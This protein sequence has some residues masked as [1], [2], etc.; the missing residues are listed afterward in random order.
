MWRNLFLLGGLP[1]ILLVNANIILFEEH[2]P[3][4]PDFAPFEYMRKRQKV[5][6][7]Y[8]FTI[9]S[10][11]EHIFHAF[12]INYNRDSHGEMVTTLCS[13]TQ[14][15]TLYQKVFISN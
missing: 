4:R 11:N 7:F 9:E 3:K 13:T 14:I 6:L 15:T 5:Y 8:L 12:F 1:A 10:I 2:H